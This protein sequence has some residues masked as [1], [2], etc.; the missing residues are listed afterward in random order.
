MKDIERLER[1]MILKKIQPSEIT[2]I[3]YNFEIL[4][5]IYNEI[6]DLDVVSDYLNENIGKKLD[7]NCDNIINFIKK[8]INFEEASNINKINE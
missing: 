7:D 3:Y 5:E 8:Y 1:K 4:K 6:K 2:Q